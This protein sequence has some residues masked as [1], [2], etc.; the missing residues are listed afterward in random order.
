M[1]LNPDVVDVL[2]HEFAWG[3]VAKL[4]LTIMIGHC[5]CLP[6]TSAPNI[7]GLPALAIQVHNKK[8]STANAS[9][10]STIR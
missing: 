6:C 8:G 1:V 10:K 5:T 2:Q 4:E 9:N 3:V 7:C